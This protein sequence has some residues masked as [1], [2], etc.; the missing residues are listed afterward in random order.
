MADGEL[1]DV[2][3][4][5]PPSVLRKRSYGGLCQENWMTEVA[6]ELTTRCPTVAKILS[7]LLDCDL[8]NPGKKLPPIC[9]L[10]GIITFLRCHELSRIQRIN[11]VLLVQGKAATNVCPVNL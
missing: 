2:A 3:R 11:T 1:V 8:T 9:L 4:R 10:Y 5:D 6:S 7:T